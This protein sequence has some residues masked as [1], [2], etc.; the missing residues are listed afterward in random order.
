MAKTK[1]RTAISVELTPEAQ[2]ALDSVKDDRGMTKKE[3]VARVISWFVSQDPDLQAVIL[4]H[5]SNDAQESL[6]EMLAVRA[7]VNVEDQQSV[8]TAA[9]GEEALSHAASRRA[10]RRARAP[11]RPKDA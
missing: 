6:L 7:R 5:V 8:Q 11:R 9:E 3:V 10:P 1:G 2:A 4:G